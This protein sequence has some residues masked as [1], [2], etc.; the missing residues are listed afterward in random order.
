MSVL[1]IVYLILDVA[2]WMFFDVAWD[3]IVLIYSMF[4]KKE[5]KIQRKHVTDSFCF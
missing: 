5:R 2:F 3:V 1:N 4:M